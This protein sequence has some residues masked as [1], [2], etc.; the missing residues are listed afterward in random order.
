VLEKRCIIFGIFFIFREFFF[1]FGNIENHLFLYL[2]LKKLS[3]KNTFFLEIA[4][5]I[6]ELDSSILITGLQPSEDGKVQR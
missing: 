2:N 6:L 3:K 4:E 1:F 5:R